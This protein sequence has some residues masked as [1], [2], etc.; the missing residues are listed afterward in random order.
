[1]AADGSIVIET[2]VDNKEA[3]AQLSALEK[4]VARSQRN[5]DKMKS[6]RLGLEEQFQRA[7][8]AADEA[9][10]KLRDLRAQLAE[11]KSVLESAPGFDLPLEEFIRY[12]EL[13]AQLPAQIA[14]QEKEYVQLGA[15]ADK[16]NE[17]LIA[18]DD[19]ISAATQE[20]QKQQE[21]AGGLVK[22]I[23]KTSGGYEQAA[24]SADKAQEAVEGL[25]KDQEAVGDTRP[26]NRAAAAYE[27]LRGIVGKL[28]HSEKSADMAKQAVKQ[29]APQKAQTQRAGTGVDEQKAA[30]ASAAYTK[31]STI[32]QKLSGTARTAAGAVS[33][34][35]GAALSAFG[36]AAKAAGAFL[37]QMNAF[38]R[39]G[40]SLSGSFSRLGSLIKSV[41]IFNVISQGFNLLKG[42]IASYLGSNAAFMAA[43][44]NLKSVLA[45]AFQPILSAAVPA[46]ITLI[47]VIS[48]V[49]AAIGRFI[50]AL[51]AIGG[52]KIKTNTKALNAEAAAIGGAGA[53]AEE[54]AKSLASFD[55]INRLA[56]NAGGGGG[57]GGGG[58]GIEDPFGDVE[59]E[60]DF[61]SWGQAFSSFLDE[62]INDG[63]PRLRAAFT[64]FAGWLNTFSH[65]LYEMFTFPGVREKIIQIGVELG[66]AFNDLVAQIDWATLG[67]A[68]GAGMNLALLLL[69]NTIYSFDWFAMGGS[70]AEMFNNMV[71]EIEW[72]EMGRLLW[73]GFK[74]A[75]ETLAGFMA[76]LNMPVVAQAMGDMIKGF[77]N[78]ALETVN[79][80]E[81]DK[82][83]KQIGI[84]L[85]QFD[86]YGTI[87][88]VLDTI[89]A[90][91]GGLKTAIDNL[92][93]TWK[94]EDTSRQISSAI[95]GAISKADWDGMGRTLGKLFSTVLNFISKTIADL[96][97][98]KLGRGLGKSLNELVHHVEWDK[99][100]ENL[101]N[102]L[103]KVLNGLSA[104]LG[105]VRWNKIG[106]SVAK[107]LQNI[108][109]STLLASVG[110][111]VGKALVAALESLVGFMREMDWEKTTREIVK[112]L[113]DAGRNMPWDQVAS[114][115]FELLGQ[116]I[117]ASVNIVHTL[118]EIIWETIFDGLNSAGDYFEDKIEE[119]GGNIVLGIMKGILDAMLGIGG[120]IKEHITGP[121]W[122]GISE[123]LGGLWDWITGKQDESLKEIETGIDK[124]C[125]N[126]TAKTGDTMDEMGRKISESLDD[127]VSHTKLSTAN[128]SNTIDREWINSVDYTHMSW[129]DIDRTTNR[130]WANMEDQSRQKFQE[131]STNVHE[132]WARAD[133]D[134]KSKWQGIDGVVNGIWAGMEASSDIRF[135]AIKN[136]VTTA[137]QAAHDD[138]NEKWPD[139]QRQVEGSLDNMS[140]HTTTSTG[141]ILNSIKTSLKAATDI[142]H[143]NWNDMEKTTGE[144]AAGAVKAAD[145]NFGK[146]KDTVKNKLEDAKKGANTVD[147]NSVG[148]NIVDGMS[149]GVRARAR[150]LA[151]SVAN[152]AQQ[153]FNA[154]KNVLAIHSPSRKFRWLFEMAMLG[155]ELGVEGNAYRVINA[156]KDVSGQVMRAF[157]PQLNVPE[158]RIP[159][160]KV[161]VPRLAAGAVIPPN[162]EFLAV[163]GDQRQ[164]NN[165]EA[166]EEL[167]RK[168]VREESSGGNTALLQA[169]LEAIRAGHVLMVDRRVLGQVVTQEQNRATRASGRAA[170]LT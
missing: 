100:S 68:L 103:I 129:E 46:L 31:L 47:N 114:L 17:K 53:A 18:Y 106:E 139:M 167:I 62:I 138:T 15:K 40:Q 39:L 104:F 118:S 101:G 60:T 52:K 135:N 92:I 30:R 51:F 10:Q 89:G 133:E 127:M 74:I 65:N 137:W 151:N 156:V 119:C 168:I 5:I 87:M 88:S 121:F 12:K 134:S 29:T 124:T 41:F 146:M 67:A 140:S 70:L 44:N 49:I 22:D 80:I 149:A 27:K 147:W 155:G 157:R 153:A 79:N 111:V 132:N 37:G 142:T 19:K 56:D 45:G 166:P 102:A 162:Q 4:A 6:D 158:I 115:I 143:T 160:V 94:W 28:S 110:D 97:V 69:A 72:A 71:A 141:N 107:F 42:Q 105:R 66:R 120:W 26:M 126:V 23:S 131:I 109:W 136:E 11:A 50:G 36:R 96:D 63:L 57:G 1:M 25:A 154:A 48:S 159:P 117:G 64:Q 98:V 99:I 55:E 108:P 144:K 125:D 3:V 8:A 122:T 73:A 90:A 112:G 32:M 123:G 21:A 86:W 85:N 170:L 161:A 34:V 145:T 84:F 38:S 116:A 152:A 93:A 77:F 7:G 128:I 24:K 59:F 76:G 130:I 61:N 13:A 54:A 33:R 163:L 83:G 165:I 113:Q 150:E 20:L 95:N 148:N 35:G 164:G 16:L 58:A 9:G 82:I 78:A 81:W 14:Q 169:I 75:L 2:H 43:L 91:L